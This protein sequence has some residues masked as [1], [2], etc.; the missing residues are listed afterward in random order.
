MMKKIL[1]LCAGRRHLVIGEVDGGNGEVVAAKRYET[2]YLNR[3]VIEPVI[4][5]SLENYIP[6]RGWTDD[7]RPSV[8]GLVLGPETAPGEAAGFTVLADRLGGIYDIPCRADR[9]VQ[10]VTRAVRLWGDGRGC[11]DFVYIDL[12]ERL[13][14]GFFVGGRLSPE[15]R[16]DASAGQIA[17]DRGARAPAGVDKT[18]LHV[19]ADGEIP[20]D[21]NEVFFLAGQGDEL[22]GRLVCDCVT[23]TAGFV[24][25]TAADLKPEKIVLGG[26]MFTGGFL[27]PK[28][29]DRLKRQPDASIPR[30]VVLSKFHPDK[31]ALIGAAATVF[32][33]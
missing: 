12:G 20:V 24:A 1:A 23:A 14:A 9:T 2:G 7:K 33:F 30:R 21:V 10:G 6:T 17:I 18:K 5:R 11:D 22:C 15:G 26:R 27:F 8:L 31:V 25:A 29:V 16:L 28:I 3:A 19:P 4:K 32:D 13:E